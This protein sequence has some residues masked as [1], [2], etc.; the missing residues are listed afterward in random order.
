MHKTL[1]NLSKNSLIKVCKM[2][3]GNGVVIIDK[4]D[5][6]N[7]LD[8][9]ILDKTRFEEINY[10][11]NTKSTNNCKLAP[12]IIQ[13]NKVIYYCRNYIKSL[14]DEKT[15]Y[16]IYPR[17]SQPGKLY[18]VVKTH[19]QNYPMRPVLSAI[20]TPEYNLAKWLEKQIKSCLIDTYSVSSSTE[21]VNKISI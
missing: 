10:N 11:L 5:Y 14:V 3:K 18:G 15:Y 20:N 17:G 16:K 6:F 4:L 1:S 2:D 21:F 8:K 7:K 9:I 13:E 19:K 12:W